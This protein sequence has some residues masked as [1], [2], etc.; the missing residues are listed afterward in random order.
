MAIDGYGELI[1]DNSNVRSYPGSGGYVGGFSP[2][3]VGNYGSIFGAGPTYYSFNPTGNESG[4]FYYE[5]A[6]PGLIGDNGCPTGICNDPG[7]TGHD[8]GNP[9]GDNG[10][11]PTTG[12]TS[13]TPDPPAPTVTPG[14]N[15]GDA[16]KNL[17]T[18]TAKTPINSNGPAYLFTPQGTSSSSGIPPIYLVVFAAIAVIGVVVYKKVK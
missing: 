17:L 8:P 2:E 3:G 11:G 5:I 10:G 16:L 14:F 9:T 6:D 15:L 12:G 1:I 18:P 13:G 7:G 4:G